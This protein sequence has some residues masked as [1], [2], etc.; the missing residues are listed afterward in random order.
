MSTDL[1]FLPGLLC[2]GDLWR[3]QIAAL[4][5]QADCK[6]ADFSTQNNVAEMAMSVLETM[7]ERFALAGLSMGGYVAL[8]VMRQAPERVERL[9]LINTKARADTEE[10]TRR[11]RGLIA[12]AQKGTFRGVTERLLPMLIHESRL[13]DDQLTG[14]V[15]KMADNIGRDGF[16]GQQ[17]AI[18]TRPD[19]LPDLVKIRCPTLVLGGR[20][21]QLTPVDCH[22]EMAAGIGTAKLVILEDCGHLSPMERPEAV[23]EA[24]LAWLKQSN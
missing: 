12:L 9:A 13:A 23:N 15:M 16:L 24:L 17:A 1:A 20:Q 8:E 7:P 21:D 2:D 18:M 10:Q 4:A 3:D 19:S 5:G 22:R 14:R 11:R 6:V